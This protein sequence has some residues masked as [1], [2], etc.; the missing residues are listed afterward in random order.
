MNKNHMNIKSFIADKKVSLKSAPTKL[1]NLYSSK[2]AG[3]KNL[4]EIRDDIVDVQKILSAD[5]RYSVLLILQG[6]DTSGKDGVVRHVF[7]GVN[8]Q[9]VRV[10]SFKKP[11]DEELAHDYL[12]RCQMRLPERGQI[13]VFNRSYYEEV[14]V[15]KVVPELLKYQN[16]P[17]ISADIWKDRY[18]E[19]NQFEERMFRNG[20][21][22]I[23][24]FLNISKDEQRKRLLERLDDREKNW[25]F[26]PGDLVARKEWDKFEKAYEECLENTSSKEC[27][28]YIIPAD[29]K[30]NARLV[31]AS[32]L[33][34][35][36]EELPLRYPELDTEIRSRIDQFKK[37]L[38]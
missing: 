36:L 16:L 17:E 38:G 23:K 22:I 18:K 30:L 33:K 1:D 28:W 21:K 15:V 32:I 8:P 5:R 7:S 27:P 9:G 37:E 25:K 29:E 20:T 2:E 35:T 34:E 19:I 11:S 31:V 6:M 14:I 13:G 24:C 4:A 3:E 10:V 12:W 26:Q